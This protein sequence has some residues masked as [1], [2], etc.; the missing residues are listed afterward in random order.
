MHTEALLN[1]IFILQHAIVI[2]VFQFSTL[3]LYENSKFK[4]T[5]SQSQTLASLGFV[6]PITK[7]CIIWANPSTEKKA[8]KKQREH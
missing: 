1:D 2:N 4:M 3:T 6:F 7:V 5:L 8:R